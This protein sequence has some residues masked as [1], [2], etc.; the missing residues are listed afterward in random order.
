[1]RKKFRTYDI[2]V[3]GYLEIANPEKSK[4]FFYK[5]EKK[6]IGHELLKTLIPRRAVIP[7]V[8]PVIPKPRTPGIPFV[9]P[10]YQDMVALLSLE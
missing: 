3:E 10:F 7:W 9:H 4:Q 8:L 6:C 5:L 1:M 2:F